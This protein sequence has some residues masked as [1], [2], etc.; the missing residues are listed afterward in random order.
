MSS[1]PRYLFEDSLRERRGIRIAAD[2]PGEDG[3]LNPLGL[4]RYF[5]WVL[6]EVQKCRLSSSLIGEIDIIAGRLEWEDPREFERSR[7]A[8]ITKVNGVG[9]PSMI[10]LLAAVG[11]ANAGGL[12]W[13]PPTDWLVAVEAKCAYLSP[14]ADS[15]L[16]KHVKSTKTSAGKVAHMRKQVS[17]LLELGFNRA[18]LLDILVNPPATGPDG[19]AWVRAAAIADQTRRAMS[20]DLRNRLP[21]G[22][23]VGHCVYSVGAVAGGDEGKRASVSTD[24]RCPPLDNPLLT[25]D[26][27]VKRRRGELEVSIRRIF[28]TLPKPPYLR[29]AYC[30]CLD[31][32]RVHREGEHCVSLGIE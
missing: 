17:G 3:F 30:D 19:G 11:L 14:Q 22:S 28:Q 23:P 15:I 12:K 13:P 5:Y 7:A 16:R 29:A 9:H 31:C 6:F 10:D 24:W 4:F 2:C 32:K 1:M 20:D 27:G 21:A 18:A 26:L 25:G 8:I